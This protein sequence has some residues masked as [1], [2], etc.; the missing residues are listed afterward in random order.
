MA[1]YPI[2]H[3]APFAGAVPKW[4]L[5]TAL[6]ASPIAWFVQLCAGYGL[7]S[8]ACFPRQYPVADGLSL[9]P[10]AWPGSFAL[11]I[12]CL[13]VAVAATLLSVWV[14]LRVRHEVSSSFGLIEAGE[15][16]TRYLAVWG[17]WTGVWFALDILFATIGMLEVGLCGN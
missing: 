1:G 15:G 16:R 10:A 14:W 3:P 8:A 11:N 7:T 6:L 5:F 12:G 4:L 13:V 17:I 2:E 9:S